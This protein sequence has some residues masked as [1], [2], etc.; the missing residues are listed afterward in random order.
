MLVIR[1][2]SVLRSIGSELGTGDALGSGPEGE[3]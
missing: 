3:I 2:Y 1:R